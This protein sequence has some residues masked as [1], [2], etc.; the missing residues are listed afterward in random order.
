MVPLFSVIIFN[1]VVFFLVARVL[2]KHSKRKIVAAKEK[3]QSKVASSTIKT[4]ISIVSVM[5]MFGMSWLFGALSVDQA[6]PVFQ[7]FFVIFSTSQG[8]LLFIFFCVIGKDA[9]EEWKKLLSCYRYKGSRTGMPTPSTSNTHRNRP[10]RSAYYTKETSLTSKGLN[11]ATIRRSVGLMENSESD[12]L[13]MSIAPLEMSELNSMTNFLNPVLEEDTDFMVKNKHAESGLTNILD[14]QLP[15][16]ILFR[17]K[18]PYYDVEES[19]V[20][21]SPDIGNCKYP[22]V[23]TDIVNDQHLLLSESESNSDMELSEL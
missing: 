23:D 17:L 10:A 12:D 5:L 3:S 7:W 9:R 19:I 2:L 16:Q 18:R 4:L 6:A 13:N 8:F 14:S 20:S 15:P 11:S 22:G 1:T 21:F